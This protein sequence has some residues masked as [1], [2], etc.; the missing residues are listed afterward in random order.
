MR[1]GELS[2]QHVHAI[3][4][5]L[6][7]LPAGCDP[8]QRATYAQQ[9]ADVLRLVIPYARTHT[10][11]EAGRRT[12]T[13]VLTADPA[14]A[15]DRRRNDAENRHGVHLAPTEPGTCDLV[16]TMP[17][18]HGEA[19]MSAVSLLAKDARFETAAGCATPGQRQVAALVALILGDPGSVG[20]IT[21]PVS[22]TK[23]K[24]HISVVVPLATI[25]TA[26]KALTSAALARTEAGPF[27]DAA[28]STAVDAAPD[29]LPG[30]RIGVEPVPADFL[31]DVLADAST[32]STIRRL[33]T[34]DVGTVIDI[35]RAH[36]TPTGLQQRLIRLRDGVCRFPG[37]TRR[38]EHCEIDHA[39]AWDAGGATDL[40]NLGALCKHHHQMKTHG[41]WQ[42]TKSDRA[43]RCT[44]RSPL[45]RIYDH[46]PDP[47]VPDPLVPDPLVPASAVPDTDEP[48]F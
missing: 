20:R 40:A 29:A 27:A 9:C 17:I 30:G 22:E 16:A 36:Y 5:W 11:G 44:W 33:V 23:I 31:R 24:A 10:P 26:R 37:C 18:A 7:L 21:G 46:E 2:E 48:P 42:I 39:V 8:T 45:G 1:A 14:K 3:A 32:D 28:T 25:T 41:R 6:P 34:D 4:R 19:I 35:G 12:K 38:A 43:G 15:R 13:L 47:L